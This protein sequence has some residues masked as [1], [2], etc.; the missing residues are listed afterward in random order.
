MDGNEKHY[1]ARASDIDNKNEKE[2][3]RNLQTN[4]VNRSPF[5]R[6]AYF[7]VRPTESDK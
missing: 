7:S 1:R 4:A 5:V 3:N 2:A 6:R